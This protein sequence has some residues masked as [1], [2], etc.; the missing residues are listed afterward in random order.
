MRTFMKKV[1]CFI[2]FHIM[3]WKIVNSLSVKSLCDL[4]L[5]L[6]D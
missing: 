5:H 4:S 3:D 2:V 6:V 1:K